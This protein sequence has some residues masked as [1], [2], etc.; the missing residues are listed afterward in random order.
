MTWGT[1]ASASSNWYAGTAP[2][3]SS[4]TANTDTATFSVASG[5]TITL[6]SYLNIKGITF[7]GAAGAFDLTQAGGGSTLYLTGTGTISDAATSANTQTIDAPIVLEG[8]SYTFSNTATSTSSVFNFTSNATITNAG[9]GAFTLNLAGTNTGSNTIAGVI[10]SGATYT[11]GVT[12]A[13]G[14]WNLAGTNTYTG[15]TSVSAGGTLEVSGSV[16]TIGSNGGQFQANGGTIIIDQGASVYASSYVYSEAGGSLTLKGALTE[17]GSS[18]IAVVTVTGAG[19]T[20]V[21]SATGSMTGLGALFVALGGTATLNGANTYNSGNSAAVGDTVNY[22]GSLTV[23]GVNGATLPKAALNFEEGTFTYNGGTTSAESTPAFYAVNMEGQSVYG[24]STFTING[25][26]SSNITAATA[27]SLTRATGSLLNL[28][29]TN[30]T[31][32][33]STVSTSTDSVGGILPFVIVNGTDF[34][35]W[36]GTNDGSI[37]NYTGY[38]VATSAA[39]PAG[40]TGAVQIN[41]SSPTVSVTANTQTNSLLVNDSSART[42]GLGGYNLN[43]N[44]IGTILTPSGTGAL[45]VGNGVNDGT[46]SAGGTTST[47]AGE[48]ILANYSSNTNVMNSAITNNQGGTGAV[49]VDVLGSGAWTLAGA[50]T[51][52]GST[53]LGMNATLNINSSIGNGGTLYIG[54]GTLDNTSGSPVTVSNPVNVETSFA[55]GGTNPLYL[56]SSTFSTGSESPTITVNGTA[57]ATI[58]GPFNSTSY[59]MVKAGPG[60][61]ALTGDNTTTKSFTLSAGTLLATNT[62]EALGSA[63]I[64]VPSG[65]TLGGTGTFTNS[66]LTL[67]SGGTLLAGNGT[68]LVAGSTT[69]GGTTASAGGNNGA[70]GILTLAL[71]TSATFTANSILEFYLGAS[72]TSSSIARS[73]GAFTFPASGST[74]YVELLNPQAGVYTLM[75]GLAASPTDLANFTLENTPGF[76]GTFMY[77]G[78]DVTLTLTVPEPKTAALM[79]LFLLA[80]VCTRQGRSLANRFRRA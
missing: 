31:F 69:V 5:A 53:Y 59:T 33:T 11:T 17:T 6:P 52:T 77:S 18:S 9:T 24:S 44:T 51:Y 32:T 63:A 54:G 35:V 80:F 16:G 21:E 78:G 20:F 57:A 13:G 40:S 1:P 15:Q 74:E 49:T 26:S 58:A 45:T 68:A 42:I 72:N 73:S 19:S 46:V 36:G 38:T 34:G 23:N 60:T 12:V 65:A 41:S 62:T 14:Y 70:F 4:G 43:F 22:G 76:M 61:L 56:S 75:T 71:T 66:T 10:S 79:G 8:T 47:A 39:Y 7:S 28:N 30:A 27:T 55:F 37:S 3:A 29:L 48:L 50:N 25:A 64:A 2:G 67:N